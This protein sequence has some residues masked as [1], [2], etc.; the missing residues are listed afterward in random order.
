MV[1]LTLERW[2]L[3]L[4]RRWCL[5]K[6]LTGKIGRNLRVAARYSLLKHTEEDK[7]GICKTSECAALYLSLVS[8]A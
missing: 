1:A 7:N 2:E 5:R 3:L 6:F 8:C 4:M